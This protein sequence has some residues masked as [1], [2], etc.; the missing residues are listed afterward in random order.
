MR[1]ASPS[2]ARQVLA[3][4]VEHRL[5]AAELHGGEAPRAAGEDRLAMIIARSPRMASSVSAGP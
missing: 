1:V 3:P 4:C 5:D 2:V